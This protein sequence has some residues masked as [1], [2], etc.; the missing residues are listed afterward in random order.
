M[1]Y[2][3]LSVIIVCYSE[4]VA[5]IFKSCA[6]YFYLHFFILF[7]RLLFLYLWLQYFRQESDPINLAKTV[8]AD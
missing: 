7:S 1:R 3:F 5:F 6:I 4:N 8:S 2:K